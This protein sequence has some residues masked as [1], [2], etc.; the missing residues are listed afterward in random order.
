MAKRRVDPW[1]HLEKH[2]W[3]SLRQFAQIIGVSYPTALKL[4][5][6][7]KVSVLD[8]GGIHRVYEPEVMRFLQEGNQ[9]PPPP[10]EG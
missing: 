8:V 10:S 5:R 9:A 1:T 2:R 3:V 4:H 6:S 7:G